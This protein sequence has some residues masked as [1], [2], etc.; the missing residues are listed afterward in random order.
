MNPKPLSIPFHLRGVQ[1]PSQPSPTQVHDQPAVSKSTATARAAQTS[2]LK[3]LEKPLAERSITPDKALSKDGLKALFG[4][5]SRHA[6]LKDAVMRKA[7]EMVNGKKAEAGFGSLRKSAF[8]LAE[9]YSKQVSDG[10]PENERLK[11]LKELR[12]TLDLMNTKH[13]GEQALRGVPRDQILAG[14]MAK[15]LQYVDHEIAQQPTVQLEKGLA[16]L[17]EGYTHLIE[18]RASTPVK[19]KFLEEALDLV[20]AGLQKGLLNKDDKDL[21]EGIAKERDLL[22][23]RSDFMSEIGSFAPENRTRK[24]QHVTPQVKHHAVSDMRARKQHEDHVER[25]MSDPLRALD[26]MAVNLDI[27]TFDRSQLKPV[28]TR[29]RTG[30]EAAKREMRIDSEWDGTAYGPTKPEPPVSFKK[31]ASPLPGD[32]SGA[33]QQTSTFKG[34]GSRLESALSNKDG[35]QLALL[36][37]QLGK[38]ISDD[39]GQCSK[40]VQ[41]GFATTRGKDF[42]NE[43]LKLL[44]GQMDPTRTDHPFKGDY[45]SAPKELKEFLDEAYRK[46]LSQ[47]PN[48]AVSDKEMVLE[49][50]TYHMKR[51][52]GEGG[53]GVALL[54]EGVKDGKPHRIVVKQP[55]QVR[56]EKEGEAIFQASCNEAR[57]HQAASRT[58]NS[59]VVPFRGAVQSPDGRLFIAMDLAEHGDM[60]NTIDKLDQAYQKG[61]ISF[62]VFNAM[63]MTLI[64]DMAKALQ[65]LQEKAGMTHL[66]VKP[67]NFFVNAQGRAQL[68]DFGLADT[69]L[70]RTFLSSPLDAPFNMAPEFAERI[71]VMEQT[72]GQIKKEDA[73][74]VRG[75][76]QQI[77]KLTDQTVK[78]R[79]EASESGSGLRLDDQ[80]ELV[81][82]IGETLEGLKALKDQVQSDQQSRLDQVRLTVDQNADTFALG[83]A[84]YKI[85]KG[86]T[87][88]QDLAPDASFNFELNDALRT[89]AKTG[90]KVT[91]L[92]Q[93][94]EGESIG[95]G[96]SSVDR[97]LNALL[98]PDPE[99]RPSMSEVLELTAF[100]QPHI[101]EPAV[102]TLIHLICQGEPGEDLSIQDPKQR[103]QEHQKAVDLHREQIQ[104]ALKEISDY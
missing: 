31:V 94:S 14:P 99:K 80:D 54:F 63:R 15:M 75:I 66:D 23:S 86:Q 104:T 1:V 3:A 22:K 40:D 37:G 41:L 93:N 24:L 33:F 47:L 103:S 82:Q 77:E 19:L 12:N 38:V 97:L 49:G 16:M 79:D 90:E 62:P 50:V 69:S 30:L 35:D 61:Q 84:A 74:L 56:R 59:S 11:T 65:F 43:L 101:G 18:G 39:V 45:D 53:N 73:Q 98:E 5:A 46:A 96:V 51:K 87:F 42:K 4:R 89:W 48:H 32:L 72:R 102:R 2:I 20:S 83:T 81:D 85:L 36:A 27:E 58:G 88:V 67:E 91:E 13:M 55:P 95:S 6:N 92:G 7:F 10:A 57:S 52:L 9:Q 25:T 60:Q 68:G 64:Q 26:Q 70:T 8:R 29:E 17:K 21:V 71:H 100:K 78:L 28:E 44:A 34:M 76:N